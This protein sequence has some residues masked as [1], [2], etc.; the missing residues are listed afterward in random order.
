MVTYTTSFQVQDVNEAKR[1]H[2]ILNKALNDEGQ[3]I[4]NYVAKIEKSE[5]STGS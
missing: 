3:S 5:L 1:L 2:L 4:H